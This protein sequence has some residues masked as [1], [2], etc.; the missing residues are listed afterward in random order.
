MVDLKKSRH[1]HHFILARHITHLTLHRLL[2]YVSPQAKQHA[3]Q[4]KQGL[5]RS[6][7]PKMA[8]GAR[9][10]GSKTKIVGSDDEE[11]GDDEQPGVCRWMRV[12][13]L[14]CKHG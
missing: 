10:C 3:T 9:W 4:N 11:E 8:A 6:E 1:V 7:V 5:G 2:P 12:C 13:L 14:I